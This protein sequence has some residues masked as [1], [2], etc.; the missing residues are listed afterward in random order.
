M[1]E[2][3]AYVTS[4]EVGHTL[5]FRHNMKASSAYTVEQLR[6]PEFTK[7]YGVEAS[8]MDYGR[9]NYVAQPGDGA[10]LIPIIGPYDEFAVEWGYKRVPRRQ[11]LRAG[12]EGARQDRRPPA[13]G[14]Q[15]P[16]RRPEPARGPLAADRGPRLRPDRAP[17]SWASRTSTASPATWSRP[18]PRTGENYDLLRDMYDQLIAQ[19]NRELGHVANVVGGFVRNN[20]W[21]PDGKKVFDARPAPT[22]RRRPCSSSN[23]HALPHAAVADRPRHPRPAR[24][25]RH[26]R[27]H[28]GGPADRCCGCS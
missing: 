12:E 11:D 7:K 20:L 21:Y 19:R 24:V 22:S 9:F 4:H 10:R 18:R 15:A 27:P 13:R 25:A 6:D 17:P 8:I 5:G 14:P 28:P 2:L 23:E 1:G 16:L 26:R 3:L